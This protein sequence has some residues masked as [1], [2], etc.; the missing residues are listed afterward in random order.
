MIRKACLISLA[1]IVLGILT[2][3]FYISIH[4]FYILEEWLLF[5][6]IYLLYNT[7][8]ISGT[9]GTGMV[10][11]YKPVWISVLILLLLTNIPF[12]ALL[13]LVLL[14]KLTLPRYGYIYTFGIAV[15]LPSTVICYDLILDKLR[16]RKSA[17]KRS[18][19]KHRNM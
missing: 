14:G 5:I 12:I 6:S 1:I 11:K 4:G 3:I 9:V 17:K 18:K 8:I 10:K 16:E 15:L 13:I 2:A 7:I 19:S